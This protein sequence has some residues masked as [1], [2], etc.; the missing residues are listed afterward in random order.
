MI[1]FGYMFAGVFI[2]CCVMAAVSALCSVIF[3]VLML[4][5]FSDN[6]GAF[7][8][9][10]F[11][12]PMNVIFSPGLLD[13]KGRR[14]RRLTLRCLAVLVTSMLLGGAMGMIIIAFGKAP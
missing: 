8:K 10:T 7:S 5:N 9:R 3:S 14:F 11:W 6:G 2:L 1:I 4:F 12:N 13:D